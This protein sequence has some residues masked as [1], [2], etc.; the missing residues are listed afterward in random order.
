MLST[1]I[2]IPDIEL[3]ELARAGERPAFDEL[4][5]RHD[6]RMRG[7]AYRLLTDRDGMDDALQEA[8]LKAFRALPRF[9]AGRDFGAWL[10]RITYNACIDDLRARKR[11]P[12][13]T[14]APAD[15][16]SGQP[17]PE[18]VVGAAETVRHALASLPLDQRVTVVLVDGEGF[19]H[20]EAAEILGV[21][22]GTVASRLHRARRLLRQILGEEVG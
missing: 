9:R 10:Y 11:A 19:D 15:P 2:T 21:A 16:I 13:T 6:G 1:S 7:L 4:L 22:P 18:R 17:G 5:R 14:E 12:L 3:V 8:Y 20:R